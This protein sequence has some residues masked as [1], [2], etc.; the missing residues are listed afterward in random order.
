MKDE[1]VVNRAICRCQFGSAPGCLK[2]TDNQS[3][4]MNGKLAA[5]DNT[6][7][8][9]FEGAGFTMCKK[10][11]PPKPCTPAITGWTGAYQGISINGSS[12]P[13][14]GTS[15]G[16]CAIGCTNCISFQTSGQI[17]I[18][19]ELQVMQSAML[20]K[21]DINP[22]EKDKPGIVTFHIYWDG[23]IEKHIP[24][25]IK[26]G[27]ENQYK[28][29]YHKK[30]ENEEQKT[31]TDVGLKPKQDEGIAVCTLSVTKVRKRANGQKP[32]VIPA[33][34]KVAYTYPKGGNAQEA[35]ID[36][37]G[38]IYVKGTEYGIR[39]FPAASGQVELVR[40]PDSGLS[41]QQ[42]GVVIRFKFSRTQRRYC[43]P[44][45][46]AGFIGALAEF[47]EEMNCNGMCFHDATS[48]PSVSHPNGDSTDIVYCSSLKKE[49]KKVNAFIHFHF[50]KIFRGKNF[51]YPKLMG[52][53]YISHHEGHLH[54]GDFDTSK[55]TIKKL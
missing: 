43:N 45:T 7:G 40:M 41:V 54:A 42:D 48:Y 37:E 13:L 16:T 20:L 38:S 46:M 11:W 2:V 8:N 29:V 22:L 9:A 3:V 12:S 33:D 1:F 35:Y 17:P 23:R 5:T 25:I 27:C 49:Q 4:C 32:K 18:P 44:E 6:L 50:T 34:L 14:L 28:Y 30:T 52:T 53:K 31:Q 24:K 26:K 47:G 39:K 36:K 51:W 19:N 10:S 55:V 21:S 15:K